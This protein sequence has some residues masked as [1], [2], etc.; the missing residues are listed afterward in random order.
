MLEDV[1]LDKSVISSE[2][3]IRTETK[4][5]VNIIEVSEPILYHN[6]NHKPM[7]GEITE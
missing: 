1:D 2:M 5:I 3:I 4:V 6:E 7:Y